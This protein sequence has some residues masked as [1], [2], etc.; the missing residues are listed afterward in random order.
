M[1]GWQTGHRNRQGLAPLPARPAIEA[2][3]TAQQKAAIGYP[4]RLLR[5]CFGLPSPRPGVAGAAAVYG[6]G[7]G[8]RNDGAARW[9]AGVR[10]VPANWHPT[11]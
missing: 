6:S 4:A 10:A 2:E 1:R 7:R 8:R 5:L 3:R 11:F 9:V